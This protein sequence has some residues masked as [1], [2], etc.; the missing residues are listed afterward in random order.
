MDTYFGYIYPFG[1]RA[2]FYGNAGWNCLV[3]PS[4]TYE[5][6]WSCASTLAS[7]PLETMAVTQ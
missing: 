1:P 2:A 4:I 5:Q 3:A 7:Y 6:A